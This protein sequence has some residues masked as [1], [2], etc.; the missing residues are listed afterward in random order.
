MTDKE[1]E[2]E[3]I[4]QEAKR[5]SI[6]ETIIEPAEKRLMW[7]YARKKSVKDEM[8]RRK[9]AQME[10]SG[11]IDWDYMLYAGH[12]ESPVHYD[13]QNDFLVTNGLYRGGLQSGNKPGY[14][15][16]HLLRR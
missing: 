4:K 7:H 16:N 13:L 11:R 3:A 6:H 1:L 12:D 2:A 15:F 8:A 10:K 9:K 5:A 14:A